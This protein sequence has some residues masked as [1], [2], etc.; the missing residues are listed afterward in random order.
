MIAGQV[1]TVNQGVP[2]RRSR[3]HAELSALYKQGTDAWRTLANP[4]LSD[5]EI[6]S[7]GDV[8]AAWFGN[9]Q[10]F[11]ITH[12][13]E[14]ANAQFIDLSQCLGMSYTLN[15]DHKSEERSKR[16]G[17]LTNLGCFNRNLD[18][19]MQTDAYDP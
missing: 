14:G 17:L 4:N 15:G 8:V 6:D 11:I 7:T 5:A 2:H 16:N 1:G 12:M 3:F 18:A 9:V 13:E 19:M 10:R